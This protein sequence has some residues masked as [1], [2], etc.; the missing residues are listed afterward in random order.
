MLKTCKNIDIP[1][2]PKKNAVNTIL[3]ERLAI[4]TLAILEM[5]I[6]VSK[7]A[8]NDGAT[9]PAS[10]WKNCSTGDM[11]CV[12]TP[13]ML[14][15]FKIEIILEKM[16]INPPII[17]IVDVLL[18]IEVANTSPKFDKDTVLCSFRYLLLSIVKSSDFLNV[19]L[20]IIPTEIEAKT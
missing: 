8:V 5:P 6:V 11:I 3:T 9:K 15:A 10:I 12:Q 20:K 16:T 2:K 17:R 14:L 1:P 4:L 7:I 13:M 19:C 18:A